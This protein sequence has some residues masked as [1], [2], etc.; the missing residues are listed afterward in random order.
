MQL[1]SKQKELVKILE[2]FIES[3]PQTPKER[4][5]SWINGF[6][7]ENKNGIYIHGGVG[8]GKTM[9]MNKILSDCIIHHKIIHFQ[10]FMQ[11]VHKAIHILRKDT[12]PAFILHKFADQYSKD[13][14]LL[15]IDELEV[16]DIADAMILRELISEFIKQN[17]KDSIYKQYRS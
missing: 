8:R 17:V 5:E 1:D 6:W 14:K 3:I 9:I 10:Q 2:R 4:V 16:K 13:L 12:D 15:L 7:K 11:D